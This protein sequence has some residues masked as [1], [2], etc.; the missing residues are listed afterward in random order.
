[1]KE[2]DFKIVGDFINE[3]VELCLRIQNDSG[4]KLVDFKK[5]LH[6]NYSNDIELL[7]N[8][9]NEFASK[10]DFYDEKKN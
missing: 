4:K 10:F 1:M 9:V 3:C 5:D 2:D 7:K 8:N 6:E